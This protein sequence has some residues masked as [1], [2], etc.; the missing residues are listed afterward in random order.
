MRAALLDELCLGAGHG[1]CQTG[2]A[3][4]GRQGACTGRCD[5]TG[6]RDSGTGRTLGAANCMIPPE[7]TMPDDDNDDDV[8]DDEDDEDEDD[9]DEDGEEEERWEVH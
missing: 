2:A 8:D 1:T 3:G 5:S 4:G 9:E 7:S 6:T